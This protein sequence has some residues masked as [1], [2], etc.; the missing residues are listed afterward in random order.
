MDKKCE[1]LIIHKKLNPRELLKM[2]DEN[3][4][5]MKYVTIKSVEAFSHY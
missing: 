5:N 4:T 3:E 1:I 2:Y